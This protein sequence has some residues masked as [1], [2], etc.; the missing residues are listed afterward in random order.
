MD[1]EV[2]NDFAAAL[3]ALEATLGAD[4]QT[5][6]A[7]V[8]AR[9]DALATA[10]GDAGL[11]EL[12]HYTPSGAGAVVRTLQS[13]LRQTPT[14]KDFGAV[15][16]GVTNDRAAF[17]L[18]EAAGPYRIPRGTYSIGSALALT[19]GLEFAPGAV[20]TGA[21]PVTLAPGSVPEIQPQ[22]FGAVGD[23]VTN[24]T[25]AFQAALNAIVGDA[26]RLALGGRHYVITT[27]T[28]P[29]AKKI[30][31]TN[32]MIT[33]SGVNS[34]G[35]A[36]TTSTSPQG[37]GAYARM[38]V[39]FDNVHFLR[40]VTGGS[41]IRID[42]AWQDVTGSCVVLPNCSFEL[43]NG[44]VGL[45]LSKGFFHKIG[46][47]Y[48][49]D[50]GE[51]GTSTAL[52]CDAS[53]AD[54]S[55]PQGPIDFVVDHASFHGGIAFDQVQP[56]GGSWNAFE[57]ARF[58]PGCSFY[59]AEFRA[60]RYNFL[61]LNGC[62]VVSAKCV[63]DSGYNTT[64]LGGYFDRVAAAHGPVLTVK[65]TIRNVL[66]LVI[67]GGTIFSAQGTAGTLVHFSDAGAAGG[68]QITNVVFGDCYFVGGVND[69]GTAIQGI[70]CDHAELRNLVVT[71]GVS[72]QN[73][74]SALLFS[75][76]VNRS[77]IHSFDARDVTYYAEDVA[78]G[79]G[80]DQYNRFDGVY[81]VRQVTLIVPTH[82]ASGVDEP[83]FVE[84]MAFPSMLR[85][86]SVS[87]A[88][89][90]S[91][92]SGAFTV[93]VPATYRDGIQINMVKLSAA[94]G[95]SRGVVTATLTLDGSQYLAPL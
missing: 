86:P 14:V 67:S 18:A 51:P 36:K 61:S 15:G 19:Q 88:D 47:R 48:K 77:V 1:A 66:G 63:L 24:D 76:G 74:Y 32:G 44:A 5:P 4:P 43:T 21:G 84:N 9:L 57:G 39:T 30:E 10:I 52:L 23:G 20:L 83:V 50:G 22:W 55:V 26:A 31:I 40:S 42:L 2:L 53:N 72:F 28:V 65:T 27:V 69:I 90:V 38:D 54:T 79:F 58:G 56:P 71:P 85:P 94:P 49:M 41:C 75:Q 93:T 6:Y 91:T 87:I 17:A 78:T 33:V 68:T 37:G 16:D 81:Q 82:L 7:S 70:R 25:A 29:N 12:L 11:G 34:Q 35:F 45:R 60:A 3:L 59:A 8:R 62:H 73:M 80:T 64:I 13:V 89:I 46:G 95:A 92:P